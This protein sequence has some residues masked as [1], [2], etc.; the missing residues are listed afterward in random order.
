M[1]YWGEV[2]IIQN[3]QSISGNYSNVT[4]NFYA[5]SDVGSAFSGYTTYPVCTLDGTTETKTLNSFN[6]GTNKRILL[7][8]ITKNV[9]HNA[10]GSKTVSASFTWD[11][12]HSLVGTVNGSATKVLTK[13]P[14]YADFT[15]H[16]ISKTDINTISVHWNANATCDA[17]QYSLNGRCLGFYNGLGLY[18]IRIKPKHEILN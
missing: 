12:G 15:E 9:Y 8:S 18:N 14:R 10:D 11:A 4:A 1:A 7:G 2:E 17:V 5:V 6:F 16:Y 13:I 3:S